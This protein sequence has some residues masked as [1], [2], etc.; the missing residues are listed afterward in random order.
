MYIRHGFIMKQFLNSLKIGLT[1]LA[2]SI[3]L[4]SVLYSFLVW[5]VSESNSDFPESMNTF[6]FVVV[7]F[8]SVAITSFLFVTCLCILSQFL[9]LRISFRDHIITVVLAMLVQISSYF[10]LFSVFSWAIF[11]N[12][13]LAGLFFFAIQRKF[14]KSYPCEC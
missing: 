13:V 9:D 10:F 11:I 5:G 12:P 8:N 4:N 6:V 2:T 7:V 14:Q 3:V 1:F